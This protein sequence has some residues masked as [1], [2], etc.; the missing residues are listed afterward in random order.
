MRYMTNALVD[1]NVLI[2]SVDALDVKHEIAVS[3]V[4][5]LATKRQLVISSQNL[6]ELS[7][8]LLD[9]VNPRQKHEDV[10]KYL[11]KFRTIGTIISYEAE[12]VISAV[13]ISNKYNVH[14]FD[15]LI[16]ATMQKHGISKI[17]TENIEDF[18]KVDWIEVVNPFEKI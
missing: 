15:A 1:T 7:R 10:I 6:A 2:Y 13:D 12:T 17:F 11:F 14:F 16:V 18:K 3:L 9:K 8:V 5:E 4:Q